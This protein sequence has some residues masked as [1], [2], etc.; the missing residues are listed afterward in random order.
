MQRFLSVLLYMIPPE[1]EGRN[2]PIFPRPAGHSAYRPHLIASHDLENHFLGIQ[3]EDGPERMNAGDSAVVKLRCLYFDPDNEESLQH[4]SILKEG[5]QV[6][7][8]EGSTMV[9]IGKILRVWDES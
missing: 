9:A 3:F 2:T 5:E 7:V 4:Y 6:R 8:V 1:L